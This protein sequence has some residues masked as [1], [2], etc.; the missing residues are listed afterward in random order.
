MLEK[1]YAISAFC[2]VFVAG[3][4]AIAVLSVSVCNGISRNPT[5]APQLRGM[6]LLFVSFIEL[7]VLLALIICLLMILK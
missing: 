5:A 7:I 2:L 6:G 3:I 4:V 1:Y